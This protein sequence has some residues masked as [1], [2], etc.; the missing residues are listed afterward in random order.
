M[1][2]TCLELDFSITDTYTDLT[3]KI[4]VK[5][6]FVIFFV[7]FTISHQRFRKKAK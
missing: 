2:K 3:I 4:I 1:I 5:I 6:V 7:I